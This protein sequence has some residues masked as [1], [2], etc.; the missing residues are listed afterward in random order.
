MSDPTLIAG[1]AFRW[2]GGLLLDGTGHRFCNELGPREHILSLG[3]LFCWLLACFWHACGMLLAAVDLRKEMEKGTR[4]FR[5]V[6]PLSFPCN[7]YM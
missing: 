2:A 6:L 4:P 1:E 3:G 5:L 7:I